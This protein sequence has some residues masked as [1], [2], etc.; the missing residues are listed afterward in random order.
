L[1]S[2]FEKGCKG[3]GGWIA[4]WMKESGLDADKCLKVH[5]FWGRE[6]RSQVIQ[7][8]HAAT[9]NLLLEHRLDEGQGTRS[10]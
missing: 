1:T 10:G 3:D 4:D 8:L 7:I 9:R 6:E 5:L 2:K